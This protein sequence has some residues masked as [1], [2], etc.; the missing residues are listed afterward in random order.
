MNVV[1]I[2]AHQDD[3]MFCLGTLLKCK[4]RGDDLFFVTLTDGSKGFVQTPDIPRKKAASIRHREMSSLAV[5]AGGRY[6]NLREHDE[7]LYDTPALRRR[8]IEV[9]RETRAHL[10][11]THFHNDY[12]TDHVTTH[13]LVKQCAMQA[14]LPVI[15]TRNA[16]LEEPPAVFLTEPLGPILFPAT[17]YVD[18]SEEFDGKVDLLKNHVSQEEA[19]QQA[20]G[21]GLRELCGKQAAF[22]GQQVGCVYAE[23]FCPMEARGAIKPYPVL[24]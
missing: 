11:F 16:P 9:L 21:A 14:A 22:R 5:A 3:E 18:I 10:V 20:L 12:N 19:L 2:M 17:H 7:F 23:C 6:I 13:I 24:P 4:K 8:L 15:R 1:S